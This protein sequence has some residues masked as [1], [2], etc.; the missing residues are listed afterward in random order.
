LITQHI[1][2][3][4][5]FVKRIYGF[6]KKFNQDYALRDKLWKNGFFTEMKNLPGLLNQEHESLKCLTFI[7]YKIMLKDEDKKTEFIE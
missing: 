5:I 4:E 6:C 2:S 7:K 1:Q 3:L